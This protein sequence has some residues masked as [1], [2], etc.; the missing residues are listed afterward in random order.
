M[1]N[2]GQIMLALRTNVLD[3]VHFIT[4]T[5]RAMPRKDISRQFAALSM[6]PALGER[7]TDNPMRK[8]STMLSMI[9]GSTKLIGTVAPSSA[10]INIGRDRLQREKVVCTSL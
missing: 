4:R 10:G 9:T 5:V 6:Y 8:P 2:G 3:P 7:A 1:M